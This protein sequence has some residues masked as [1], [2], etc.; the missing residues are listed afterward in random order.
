MAK[1]ILV[2]ED[3]DLNRKLFCDVLKS[4][5]YAVEPV[6]DGLDAL[7][8]AR[9]FVPN[10]MIMDI[11]MPK[12]DGRTLCRSVRA[13]KITTPILMLT[14]MSGREDI[15][16]G[17]DD[18]ADDYLTKPFDFGVLLA[19]VRALTRRG[20]EQRT[21]LI[22]V[23]DLTIDTARRTVERGGRQISL[24]SKEFALLEYLALNEGKI[25]TRTEISEHV[26]D[27]NFDPKSNVIESLI[28]YLRQSIDKEYEVRLIHT[29]RG[30]GYRFGP[31][32]G[33][34]H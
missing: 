24:T 27:S 26:W 32:D 8:R 12:M 3:N 23:A 15:I 16:A 2:V 5:G 31:Y 1:R 25:V 14:A 33:E 7:D 28:S 10:L 29:I 34:R 11:H 30:A 21:A 19:R 17:L 18:G 20:S 9:S 4:Q 6:A 22:Q 13:E